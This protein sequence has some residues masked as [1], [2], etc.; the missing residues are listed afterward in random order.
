MDVLV[1]P[2]AG[3]VLAYTDRFNLVEHFNSPICGLFLTQ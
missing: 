1:A 2:F 3:L